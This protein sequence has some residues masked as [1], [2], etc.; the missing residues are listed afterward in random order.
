VPHIQE[1]V[2]LTGVASAQHRMQQGTVHGKLCV[3][4]GA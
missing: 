2:D 4:V 3:R 1:I